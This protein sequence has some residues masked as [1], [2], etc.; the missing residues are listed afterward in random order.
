M[1]A[2]LFACPDER[3]GTRGLLFEHLSGRI[4]GSKKE[5]YLAE[6]HKNHNPVN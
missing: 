3:S 1:P 2:R 4:A 6:G 5:E